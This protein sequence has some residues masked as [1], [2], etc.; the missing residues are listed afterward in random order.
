MLVSNYCVKY[1]FS[2]SKNKPGERINISFTQEVKEKKTQLS[3]L[4]EK[5]WYLYKHQRSIILSEIFENVLQ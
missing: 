3:S 2:L 4:L 5:F 1:L